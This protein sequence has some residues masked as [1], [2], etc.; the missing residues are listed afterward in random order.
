MH[1]LILNKAYTVMSQQ[2]NTNTVG[3]KENYNSSAERGR[4][5]GQGDFGGQRSRSS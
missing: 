2:T 1:R 4:G 3:S 5:R